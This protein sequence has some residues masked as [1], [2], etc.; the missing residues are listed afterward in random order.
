MARVRPLRPDDPGE[1]GGFRLRGRLGSGG[2]GVVYLADS[3]SGP[4]A[5]KCLHPHVL[6]EGQERKI[7]RRELRAAGRVHPFCTAPVLTADVEGGRPYIVSEY[8]EGPTL[9]ELVEED[10][11]LSA[12]GLGRLAIGTATALTAI[13]RAG[14]VH[15]DFKP[16]TIVLGADGPR[17]IDVGIARILDVSSSLSSGL[18]GTPAFLAPDGLRT[19]RGSS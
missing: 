13:H 11:P 12:D 7:L 17:V 2:Q 18:V 1:I 8:V 10:G 19:G 15:R 3:S 6:A 16:G 9:R 5:V 4:V 14:I